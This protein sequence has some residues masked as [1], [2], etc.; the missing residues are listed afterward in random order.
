[1]ESKKFIWAGNEDDWP[2]FQ[3]T[4]ESELSRHYS[5]YMLKKDHQD[6]ATIVNKL[7]KGMFSIGGVKDSRS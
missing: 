3:E 5:T 6:Y 4:I 1:M 7:L 2:A